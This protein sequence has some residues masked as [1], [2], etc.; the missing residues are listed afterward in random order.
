MYEKSLAYIHDK[1]FFDLATSAANFIQEHFHRREISITD[2]GC[3]SGAFLK[4]F[5]GKANF[6]FG[7]D[8]SFEMV[9]LCQKT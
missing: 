2:L 6:G 5:Y 1:Y 4:H 3:G 9:K 8:I 7:I